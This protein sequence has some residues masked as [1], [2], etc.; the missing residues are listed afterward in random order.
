M[1]SLWN[2]AVL[3][4]F[5][6]LLCVFIRILGFI[7]AYSLEGVIAHFVNKEFSLKILKS[8]FKSVLLCVHLKSQEH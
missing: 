2:T 8:C 7:F 4:F 3:P 1:Y 6:P 5:F